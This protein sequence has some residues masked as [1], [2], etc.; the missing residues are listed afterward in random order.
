[1]HINLKANHLIVLGIPLLILFSCAEKQPEF[2]TFE[3]IDAH[4]HV[5]YTGPEFLEQAKEDNFKVVIINLDHHDYD[6]QHDWVAEQSKILGD[7]FIYLTYFPIAGWDEPD[8]QEKTISLLKE[9]FAS[10][11]PT[12]IDVI[13]SDAESFHKI[14]KNLG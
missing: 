13:T 9:A 3:K 14:V 5:R 7:Q 1:M 4:V 8:W 12:V 11:E 6:M 10:G 2:A